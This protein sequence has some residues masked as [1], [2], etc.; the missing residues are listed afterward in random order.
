[1]PSCRKATTR[2]W[3]SS[4]RPPA[5]AIVAALAVAGAWGAGWMTAAE[6]PSGGTVAP[7]RVAGFMRA[8]LAHSD[9]VLEGLA[10]ADYDLIAK[11][12]QQLSLVSQDASWQVLQTEDYARQSVEFRRSCDGLLR[13]AKDENLDAAVLAWMDVTMKCVQCHRYVRDVQHADSDAP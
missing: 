11:G 12:A 1:M 3:G 5:W 6:P 7:D 10:L 2:T 9:D 13:A 4:E 8:K